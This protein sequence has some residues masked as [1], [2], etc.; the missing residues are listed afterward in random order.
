MRDNS[1]PVAMLR[2]A[3]LAELLGVARVTLRLWRSKGFGPPHC[4][5]NTGHVG[6]V[7][8]LVSDV[9]AWLAT[10][11]RQSIGD[12]EPCPAP[13]TAAPTP[14]PT[15]APAP[16]QPRRRRASK[17]REVPLTEGSFAGYGPFAREPVTELDGG[18]PE[19]EGDL[20]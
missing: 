18:A 20:P 7:R 16:R 1:S 4:K 11:R 5:F 2:E 14:A 17:P 15:A 13:P 19:P 8:Y 3:E 12:T 6:A 9:E 10:R